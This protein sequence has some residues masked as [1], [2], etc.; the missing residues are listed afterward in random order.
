MQCAGKLYS[1]TAVLVLLVVGLPTAVKLDYAYSTG[2][3]LRLQ[4]VPTTVTTAVPSSRYSCTVVPIG[5]CTSGC[6]QDVYS[7]SNGT[8]CVKNH[9]CSS[10]RQCSGAFAPF[11]FRFSRAVS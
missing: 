6:A 11:A 2:R 9:A 5:T 3:I 7:V 10:V 4:H 1:C 8:V